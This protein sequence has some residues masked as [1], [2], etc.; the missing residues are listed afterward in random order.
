MYLSS[1]KVSRLRSFEQQDVEFVHPGQE[2][3]KDRNGAGVDNVTL[4]LGN[5]GAGKTTVLKAIALAVLGPVF[6]NSGFVPECLIRRD[7]SKNKHKEAKLRAGLSLHGQDLD[8]TRGFSKPTLFSLAAAS[9]TRIG[10]YERIDAGYQDRDAPQPVSGDKQTL[11]S[12]RLFDD[13]SPAFF[14][15]GYG[16][17]RRVASPR[18]REMLEDR[19]RGLRYQRVSGLFEDYVA[20]FPMKLWLPELQQRS[21]ARYKE[22]CKLLNQLLPEDTEFG[23]EFEDLQP[24]FTHRGVNLPFTALSDGY[25]GFIGVVA[26]MLYHLQDICPS[27]RK[28][29]DVCGIVMIDDVDIHMHPSWQRTV[30]QTLAK[31]LPNIQF[32]MTSHSPILAG[33]VY[34]TNIRIVESPAKGPSKV[35]MVDARVHGL[36]ADQVLTGPLFGLESTRSPDQVQKLAEMAAAVQRRGKPTASLDFLNELAGKSPE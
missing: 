31:T 6:P 32:V 23:G 28:L 22:V 35:R 13:S 33:T 27:R 15:L 29:T 14:L 11:D 21:K 18:S 1:L 17:T 9:I 16:A 3:A 24:V 4:L 34:S 30:V 7:T 19:R 26:D 25:R 12:E 8:S 36:N 20:L 2:K 5:N 10:D